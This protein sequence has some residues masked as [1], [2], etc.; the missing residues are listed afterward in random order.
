MGN[1]PFH[2]PKDSSLR[3][4]LLDGTTLEGGGQLLRIAVGLSA[5]TGTPV[6]IR[7]IRGNR[8]GG[9]G[10][11]AQHLTALQWLGRASKAQIKGLGLKSKEIVFRPEVK[12]QGKEGGTG[13]EQKE[14]EMDRKKDVEKAMRGP[15]LEDTTTNAYIDPSFWDIRQSTPGSVNLVFQ[16]ILPYVL[17]SG[18]TH[19]TGPITVRITG[20]TNVSNSPSYEYFDQ[21]LFPM[22]EK[23]GVP[24]IEREMVARGWSQGGPIRLGCVEYKVTPLTQALPAFQLTDRG[25][26]ESVHATVLAPEGTES[27]FRDMLDDAAWNLR[28]VIFSSSNLDRDSASISL[29]F[30]DSEHAKRYYVLLVATT[31]T[32]MKLGRDVL[33]HGPTGMEPFHIVKRIVK[34]VTKDLATEI[35]KGGC[36]DEHLRDQLVVFQGLAEGRSEVFGGMDAT[37]KGREL[38]EPNLHAETAM[39]VMSSMVRAGLKRRNSF[40]WDED[41]ICEGIGYVPGMGVVTGV[42]GHASNTS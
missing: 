37:G 36:V 3:P 21:V 13:A 34:S 20:G 26:V 6:Q 4:V 12:A 39:Y 33:Y 30:E 15:K 18:V 28:G 1:G 35:Q 8:S 27:Q 22:L 25:N 2:G 14:V 7:N 5:L 23:I 31:S 24:R 29:S 38:A 41:G 11:K 17:F 19:T 42:E 10:L 40:E 16:A 9:G 32:G